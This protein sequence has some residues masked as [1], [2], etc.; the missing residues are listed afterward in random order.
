V[1]SPV[2]ILLVDDDAFAFEFLKVFLSEVQASHTLAWR[3]SYA[4]GMEAICS[5]DFDLCLLDYQLGEHSGLDFLREAHSKDARTPI[6]MLTGQG[7]K[8]LDH[9]AQKL[10]AVDYLV[11]GGFDA[12]AF[13]RVVRYAV[14]RQRTL[15]RLR[16]SEERYALAAQG[17]NDGI[18]DWEV[19]R[20]NMH[21]SSRW[22]SI[23]GFTDDEVP[24][25][26]DTWLGRVHSDDLGRLKHALD[27]HI[28]GST[29]HFE[30]EHRLLHRDG[31]WRHVLV[32]GQAVRDHAGKATRIAGSLTDVTQ[33][34]SKDP[35]T[36]L[37]NRVLY[38][39][40]L[41]RSFQRARRDPNYR[42]ALLFVDLDRFKIV[43]DSLG[44][45]AGDELLAG[46]AKRLERC[47]RGVDTVA[48]LGG[49]EFTIILDDVREPD[50]AIRVATRIIE[51][52]ARPF[53]LDKQEV[54]TGASIG[55]AMYTSTYRAPQDL[56]RDA[57][58]AMYRAK[59]LGKARYVVF[60][61]AMHEKA[62]SVL[63]I[64]TEL[65]RAI[66]AGHL[67]AFY[68]PVLD[69]KDERLLGFEALVRWK[70]PG[71]GLI[72]PDN[73]VPIAEDSSLIVALDRFVLRQACMQ[74]ERW[75]RDFPELDL[76]M[77]V[78]ASRRQF[79]LTNC[80]DTLAAILKDASVPAEKL[81]LEVTESVSMDPSPVVA[82]QLQR[83]SDLGVHLVVDDFGVGYSSLALL[84]KYPFR[85][86]KIDRS[87]ISRLDTQ[88]QALEVVKA[89]LA[90]GTAL[91][92]TVTA[93]GVESKPQLEML[94]SLRCDHAQGYYFSAP[95]PA[96]KA[97][98]FIEQF[99]RR[100]KL[101]AR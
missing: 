1:S 84:N 60:D 65:R 94:R 78:N 77:S 69:A 98:A 27:A 43:N 25:K 81:K 83:V 48:R 55:I 68:Q 80:A 2:R 12:E 17:S 3:S 58:T 10:G 91:K 5:S 31:T 16:V 71:R 72:A 75:R 52:V 57:D 24:D 30:N 51:E 42:F 82:T 7:D 4:A 96:D 49:D 62:M 38:L 66:D 100:P 67:E 73:F 101:A 61:H 89:I 70:H 45:G 20:E 22:K 44:H 36:G 14:E 18:W 74:L 19:G 23:I 54:F 93:E 33:S 29:H 41:E 50:G 15:E 63:T 47:L 99:V 92:L 34:R 46:I 11:K 79:A 97:T 95:L 13:D 9:E 39:D 88:T 21:L 59:A 40:R 86:L 53:E 28:E 35:L 76:T 37:P 64:E 32:R 90:M 26:V 56:L 6:V 85:A 87:F 8:K